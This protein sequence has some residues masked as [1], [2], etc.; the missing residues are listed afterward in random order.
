M[1]MT[2]T[3]AAPIGSEVESV[4]RMGQPHAARGVDDDGAPGLRRVGLLRNGLA[5]LDRHAHRDRVDRAGERRDERQR[6]REGAAVV[7]RAPVAEADRSVDDDGVR[8]QLRDRRQRRRV[9]ERLERRAGLAQR[10][11]GAIELALPVVAPADHRAHRA[12]D[13]HE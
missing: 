5:D 11:D 6:A 10:I 1:S 13:V 12:V 8:P 3:S 4:Q 7:L 9:D 2:V